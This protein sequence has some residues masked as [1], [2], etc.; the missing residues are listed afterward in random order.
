MTEEKLVLSSM[1]DISR[2]GNTYDYTI[3]PTE[4]QA[5]TIEI[6]QSGSNGVNVRHTRPDGRIGYEKQFSFPVTL[7]RYVN[8]YPRRENI[9]NWPQLQTL[10]RPMKAKD[11][12]GRLS[13]SSKTLG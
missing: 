2:D 12:R 11:E 7:I 8:G 9:P 6:T 13:F 10:V 5:A 1:I 3:H 4:Y